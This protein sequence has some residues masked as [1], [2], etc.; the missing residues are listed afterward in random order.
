MSR[1][2][3]EDTVMDNLLM[4]KN[5]GLPKLSMEYNVGY[6]NAIQDVIEIFGYIQ[7]DLK[8]HHK[9]LNAKLSNALLQCILNNRID[10]RDNRSRSD[11]Y[12]PFIRYTNDGNFEYY[13]PLGGRK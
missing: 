9:N 12:V 5:T 6:T 3:T 11:R 8:Y 1:V 4:G 2:K 13:K 10:I 7:P